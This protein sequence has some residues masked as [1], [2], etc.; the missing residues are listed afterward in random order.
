MSRLTIS[1]SGDALIMK[2]LPPENAGLG[3]I[4]DW[5]CGAE[6]RLT[7]LETTVTDG[8]CPPVAFSGGTWLTAPKGVLEDLKAYGFNLIGWANNHCLDYSY[9]GLEQTRRALLEADI[10][11][12]GAGRDLYEAASPTYQEGKGARCALISV[13]STFTPSDAAGERTPA[14]AGRPGL[15]PLRY[16]T[17]CTVT[18]EHMKALY[19]IA[20]NTE[21]NG[22]H[23]LMVRQGFARDEGGLTLGG[24]RFRE[25]EREERHTYAQKR[26]VDRCARFVGEALRRADACVVMTHSHEMPG[27]REDQPDEFLVEFAHAMIDA[28]ASAVVG[29]GTHR[30]KPIE[31]YRGRPIFYSLG[32]FIFQNGFAP[33]LPWDFL[34][35]YGLPVDALAGEALERRASLATAG[36]DRDNTAYLSALPR[37]A[38]EDGRLMSLELMPIALDRGSRGQAGWPREANEEEAEEI[39]ST[40][41]ALSRP[42]GTEME[43]K[44]DRICIK[45]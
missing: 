21:I 26:D 43:Q 17:V 27:S 16:D 15:N 2:R 5:L 32:N 9:E 18:G 10:P 19:D 31:L 25:G 29:G 3:P 28:G 37:M 34:E 30:L 11:A 4:R 22:F 8:A 14:C 38:F 23:D 24:V 1:A 39:F 12:A 7:N 13:C 36:L 33:R 45:I 6:V 44:G 42:Y 41:S 35:K 20:A 40:L